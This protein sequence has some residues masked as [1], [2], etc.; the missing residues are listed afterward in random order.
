MSRH[1]LLRSASLLLISIGIVSLGIVFMP[2]FDLD[3]QKGLV[4]GQEDVA[5]P[6]PRSKIVASSNIPNILANSVVNLSGVDYTSAR[7]W[8]PENDYQNT[9][10]VSTYSLTIPKLKIEKALVSTTN[11]DL[12]QSLVHYGGSGI[13]GNPGNAVVF[14]HSTLPQ[15]FNPKNYKT[16]FA[17]LHTLKVGDEIFI[18]YDG[19]V[20][21]FVIASRKIIDP[22]DTSVLAQDIDGSFLTLITCTPPGTYWKRLVL[23]AKLE[24]VL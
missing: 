5:I 20:Y 8:F 1:L 21:K 10:N 15:L 12:S 19:I 23:K 11:D 3:F 13:P 6:I 14:G 2:F 22:T 4:L 24:K 16:I 18:E 17:T 7:N 9:Q